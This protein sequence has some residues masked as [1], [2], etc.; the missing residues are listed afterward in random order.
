[1]Y[2]Y[3]PRHKCQLN[4]HT[5][6]ATAPLKT[7][8]YDPPVETATRPEPM[9]ILT[10]FFM[11][12]L[13]LPAF[14]EVY[15]CGNTYT[16]E[17]CKNGKIVDTSPP[18]SDPYARPGGESTVIY[19]CRNVAGG[20]FWTPSTCSSQGAR[21]ERSERVPR[22][23]SWD[24]QVQTA[25]RQRRQGLAL[26]E[27]PTQAPYSKPR[28]DKGEQCKNLEARVQYLDAEGRRGGGHSTMEWLREER[29]KAR[30]AQYRLRC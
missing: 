1:M 24:E 10:P 3:H 18:L 9:R 16:E 7:R 15:R 28:D 27:V 26:A 2:S 20:M 23:I 19:L 22:E 6:S 30:D 13:A 25:R 29:R 21:L 11:L 17:P 8:R 5:R 12:A 14:A 4:H